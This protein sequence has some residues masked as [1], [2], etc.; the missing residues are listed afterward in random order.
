MRE[1]IPLENP[2]EERALLGRK[3]FTVRR[4]RNALGVT[5]LVRNGEIIVEGEPEVAKEGA[6]VVRRLL[7]RIRAGGEVE[8]GDVDAAVD[9][10]P[11]AR[12]G[13]LGVARALDGTWVKP[14]TDGQRRYVEALAQGGITLAIGPAGTGKT[15]LAVAMA[16]STLRKSLFR[17]LILVRPAVEAGERLGFLPGDLQEKVNPYLRPLYDALGDLLDFAE[18]Q[19]YRERDVIEIAPLAFMRGR[20]LDNAFIILDE[21]QNTKPDQMKMFLTR[22]GRNSTIVA[23]GDVTQID[24]PEG[25]VSGL[26]DAERVL[27]GIEGVN[28]VYLDKADIVRHPLVQAIV[29]AYDRAGRPG[30]R[31]G[32]E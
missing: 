5:L 11:A 22:M 10:V 32:E 1:V 12:S 3:D 7:E 16:V 24:L 23:T 31:A 9:D 17:K 20:T 2:D 26:R 21:A 6:R 18:I 8:E 27:R 15:Y 4:L 25:Q 29:S 30:S 28:F 14:R 19:R 13:G